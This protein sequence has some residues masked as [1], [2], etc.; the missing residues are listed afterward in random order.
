M[1]SL[2]AEGLAKTPK[3]LSEIVCGLSRLPHGQ[4]RA[5]LFKRLEAVVGPDVGL[6]ILAF[7]DVAARESGRLRAMREDIGKRV[8]PSDMIIGGIASAMAASLATRNEC[9]FEGLGLKLINPWA[10]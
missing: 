9:D 5:S 3:G 7:D 2:S 1:R 4:R 6:P 8:S 10:Q